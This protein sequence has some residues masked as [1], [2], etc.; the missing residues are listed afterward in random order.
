MRNGRP[1]KARCAP[2]GGSPRHV[3]NQPPLGTARRCLP[4]AP[5]P[6]PPPAVA[7]ADK[8]VGVF[9]IAV[10]NERERRLWL[11][12]DRMGVKPL[13]YAFDGSHFWF[14]SEL[15]ALRAFAEWQPCIDT[16]ALGEYLQYGYISA[17][18]SIYRDVRKLMP[19]HWLELGE[20][21]EP[22]APAYWT[23]PASRPPP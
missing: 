15:K 8:C 2:R 14:G 22:V 13:Y 19:G 21:G 3:P 11:L 6:P 4:L 12:R 23:P 18:R 16:D 1:P 20:V 9:G 10:W 5:P 7:A 17:P